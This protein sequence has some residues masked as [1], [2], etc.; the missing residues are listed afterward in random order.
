MAISLGILTQH[1]QTKP[2]RN[3]R[4]QDDTLIFYSY[5]PKYQLE[6]LIRNP[7]YRLYDPSY[8]QL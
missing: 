3:K 8:D 6:V 2:D 7:N 4:F 5:G 1:F